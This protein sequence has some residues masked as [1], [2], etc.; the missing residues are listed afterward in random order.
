[1]TELVGSLCRS[2][3]RTRSDCTVR[4]LE[5]PRS[6]VSICS[7]HLKNIYKC[8]YCREHTLEDDGET[9]T[10]SSC[11]VKLP[12][13]DF[14]VKSANNQRPIAIVEMRRS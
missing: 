3:V 13:L 10:C 6:W 9:L 1:M 8:P 7:N 11:G 2:C 12:W 5:S 14:L 4:N